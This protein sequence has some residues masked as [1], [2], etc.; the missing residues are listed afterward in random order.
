MEGIESL[1]QGSRTHKANPKRVGYWV[2]GIP[3]PRCC[4]IVIWWRVREWAQEMPTP[5]LENAQNIA[6]CA[7]EFIWLPKRFRN[8][9]FPWSLGVTGYWLSSVRCARYPGRKHLH[10]P[11][12]LGIMRSETAGP[13]VHPGHETGV[14]RARSK[15]QSIHRIPRTSTWRPQP[16]YICH[17]ENAHRGT[18]ERAESLKGRRGS[19]R[20]R[21]E[22]LHSPRVRPRFRRL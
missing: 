8:V 16:S 17:A 15:H 3:L 14:L 5:A 19:K 18:V 1:K 4:A 11:L 13:A 21:Y 22:D 12:A 9:S 7:A 10:S 20:N 2:H 6:M